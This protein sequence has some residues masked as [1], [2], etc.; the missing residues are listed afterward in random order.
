VQLPGMDAAARLKG[1]GRLVELG[2]D[3]GHDTAKV[4]SHTELPVHSKSSAGNGFQVLDGPETT[5]VV[6]TYDLADGSVLEATATTTA[7]FRLTLEPPT[8]QAGD[9]IVGTLTIS[10]RSITKRI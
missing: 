7:T 5:D 9:P 1:E 4:R 3:D 8:G 6:A 10:V 2:T